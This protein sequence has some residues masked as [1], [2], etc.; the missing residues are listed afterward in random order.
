MNANI[1]DNL[2]NPKEEFNVSDRELEKDKKDK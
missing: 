1:H 2:I